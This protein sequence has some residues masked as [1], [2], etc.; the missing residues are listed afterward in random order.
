MYGVPADPTISDISFLKETP[1]KQ[2]MLTPIKSTNEDLL[3]ESSFVKHN[4]TQKQLFSS[5]NKESDHKIVLEPIQS[6]IMDRNS[7]SFDPSSIIVQ[8]KE[9]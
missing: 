4:S 7:D 8:E 5:K 1:G 6:I 9:V 3:D 2:K